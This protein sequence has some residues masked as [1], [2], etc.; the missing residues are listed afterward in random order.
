MAALP[1]VICKAL[2]KS[3]S[4]CGHHRYEARHRRWWSSGRPRLT[5]QLGH[6][7]WILQ[8]ISFPLQIRQASPERIHLVLRGGTKNSVVCQRISLFAVG[9]IIPSVIWACW[10][11]SAQLSLQARKTN[12]VNT[13]WMSWSSHSP[14]LNTRPV[15]MCQ[16]LGSLVLVRRGLCAS[17]QRSVAGSLPCY[18]GTMPEPTDV[19]INV[20]ALNIFSNVLGWLCLAFVWIHTSWVCGREVKAAEGFGFT[21]GIGGFGFIILESERERTLPKARAVQCVKVNYR[22]GV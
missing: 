12:T 5:E 11:A 19:F 4:S 16:C 20:N 8:S 7:T 18:A 3:P 10:G 14:S 2:M 6:L 13:L 22:G 9:G 21:G 1:F 17:P 15:C